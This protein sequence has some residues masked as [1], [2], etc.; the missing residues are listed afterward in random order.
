[1]NEEG[2]SHIAYFRTDGGSSKLY[3]QEFVD[4]K[5]KEI[6]RLEQALQEEKKTTNHAYKLWKSIDNSHIEKIYKLEQE[7]ERLNK[8]L[9]IAKDNEETYRLEMLD[10]TK[11]LGL[12][13]DTI[14]DEVKDKAERLKKRNKEI[15]EGFIATQDELKEYAEENEQLHSIIK[16]AREY[17][18]SNPLVYMYD[19]DVYVTDIEFLEGEIPELKF[20]RTLN[21][22][23][24]KVDKGE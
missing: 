22:I 20:F 4:K 13:E 12:K 14:F 18:E 1:M 19:T 3:T 21:E 16:E 24:D 9:E 10:I 5:D 15:Y 8:E 7:I 2:V 23:L 6:E 11:R 17:I